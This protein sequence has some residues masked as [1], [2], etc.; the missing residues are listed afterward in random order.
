MST[1]TFDPPLL[2]APIAALL[3][4]RI[5]PHPVSDVQLIQTHISYVVLAG[6]FVYKV[7]KP[8]NFGF[9]DFSTPR[10]RLNDCRQE[11]EL[12]R[13]LCPWLYL[14]VVA[15]TNDGE[16]Y[17]L[18]GRGRPAEYAV[19]MHRLP[20]ERMMDNLLAAGELTMG[21]VEALAELIAAFHD[22]A[23]RGPGIERYGSREYI[24]RNWDENFTQTAP[25]IGRTISGERHRWLQDWVATFMTRERQLFARR[26]TQGRIR[27]CH[28][29]LRASAVCYVDGICVFDCI[30]FNRRF[31]YSDV[32]SD[33]AFLAM[34][35][36]ARGRADLA[37]AFVERYVDVSADGEL[38]RVLPFYMCYR[39]YVRGKVE[40]FRL[41]EPEVGAP[42]R[43]DAA[44]LA[45]RYFEMAVEY[46]SV[47]PVPALIIICGLS[48]SG[49]SA[50]ADNL[51]QQLGMP[52]ISSD[53]V[54]KELA[55][56]SPTTRHAAAFE[57]GLY[58]PRFTARTYGE[59]L[60]RALRELADGRSVILDATY[61]DRHRREQVRRSA[62]RAGARFVCLEC[63][64]G[65][66]A[67]RQRLA[68]R[69]REPTIVSD[70]RWE[71]YVAQRAGFDAV[72]EL[73][74]WQHVVVD[75]DRPLT[76]CVAWAEAEVRP[77][78]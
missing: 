70:A 18:A 39:A 12:N 67:I 48:G 15:I 73:D 24:Q 41:D 10:K 64:A 46:A 22:G 38:R 42:D 27:D 36:R 25:Y 78:L 19:K 56:T 63:V 66:D 21:M 75:M 58:A 8:V 52:V 5:Y 28:G 69:E 29:D 51:A 26:I 2:P 32:A 62:A 61:G 14:G 3:D 31:R 33:V 57:V 76:E 65:E 9:L 34:D 74:P 59:L 6:E 71:T 45:R 54:R 50:L 49:K 35:L 4:P 7:R 68:Q 16:R 40:S 37:E 55:G 1:A 11:V 17:A 47:I 77:R 43:Q 44:E 13:R 23:E 20:Q 53:L 30:E 60:R 72:D